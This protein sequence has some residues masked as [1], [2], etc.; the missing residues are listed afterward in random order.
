MK[1]KQLDRLFLFYV[2]AKYFHHSL[3]RSVKNQQLQ[4]CLLSSLWLLFSW[5]IFENWELFCRI[6]F[7]VCLIIRHTSD[8]GLCLLVG[9][10]TSSMDYAWSQRRRRLDHYKFIDHENKLWLL[11]ALKLFPTF[12]GNITTFSQIVS[13]C[14]AY[15]SCPNV[16][17]QCWGLFLHSQFPMSILYKAYTNC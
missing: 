3:S 13:E 1:T 14:R 2:E 11:P 10:E 17:N 8:D 5:E 9:L 7:V 16:M 15:E 6:L 4:Q 12:I